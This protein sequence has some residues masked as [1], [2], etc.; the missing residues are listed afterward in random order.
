ME[1]EDRGGVM[2]GG[3]YGLVSTL[4]SDCEDVWPARGWR[5]AFLLYIEAVC[6]YEYR[7]GIWRGRG[8]ESLLGSIVF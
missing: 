5:A 8:N 1:C 6:V 3:D 7:F 2:K 4:L